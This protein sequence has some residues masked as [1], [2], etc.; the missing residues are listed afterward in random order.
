M[1]ARRAV[2]TGWVA[3]HAKLLAAKGYDVVVVARRERRLKQPQAELKDRFGVR[4]HPLPCDLVA[5]EASASIAAELAGRSLAVDFLVNNAG[6][7]MLGKFLDHPW[8]EHEKFV[9][10]KSLGVAELCHRLLPHMRQQQWG[11]IINVTSVGGMFLGAPTMAL[12]TAAKSFVHKLSEA[13]DGEYKPDGVHRTV[14]APGATETEIFDVVGITDY[15]DNNLPPQISMMRPE[16]VARQAYAGCME[17]KKVVVHGAP[18]KIW[19]PRCCTA[20]KP[21][22][23][24]SSTPSE[25]ARRIMSAAMSGRVAVVTG[26]GRGLGQA[27]AQRLHDGTTVVVVDL[28]GAD[29]TAKELGRTASAVTADVSDEVGVRELISSVVHRHGQLD[30]VVNNAGIDGEIGPL[31]DCSVA[32]FDRIFAVNTRGV[33]LSMKY[34]MPHLA[35][36]PHAAVVNI[37]SAAGLRTIPGMAAHCAAKSAVI[38]LTQAAA[39]EYG[40][41]GVRINAILPGGI[42][43]SM[44]RRVF[45]A[46]PVLR[47]DLTAR[48]PLGRLGSPTE[49]AAGVGFL[50]SDAASFISGAIVPVD[51][52]FVA[53]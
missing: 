34:A 6:F 5:A 1:A 45:D 7:D 41:A 18:N 32:N 9:R 47:E 33:F 53:N 49:L 21:S 26:A 11:R 17:G 10:L 13:I 43:T 36:S 48:H 19:A 8:D 20:R 30:I 37:A 51:G 28:G 31:A 12:Y 24:G 35:R 25:N 42:E 14:S 16:T 40:P 4:I 52:T 22:A 38:M 46:N 50:V 44:P 3:E 15:W 2:L 29:I 23:T 27:I 39:A